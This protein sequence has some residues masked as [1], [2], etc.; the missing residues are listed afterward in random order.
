MEQ[1]ITKNTHRLPYYDSNP[2]QEII[3]FA[4]AMKI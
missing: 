3:T 2:F 1:L 4:K